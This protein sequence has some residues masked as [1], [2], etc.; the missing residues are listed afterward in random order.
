MIHGPRQ[1]GKTTLSQAVGRRQ[2]YTYVTFDDA[3]TREAATTDPIGFVVDL[4]RRVILDEVQHVPKLFTTLK[5]AIDRN[6]EPGIFVLTGS[7][8]VL[9]L[10]KLADSLAGRIVILRLNRTGRPNLR[11]WLSRSARAA[12]MASAYT[13]VRGLSRCHRA[14]RLCCPNPC[15]MGTR[16]TKMTTPRGQACG[17]ARRTAGCYAARLATGAGIQPSDAGELAQLSAAGHGWTDSR[18]HEFQVGPGPRCR[19]E[20][21]AGLARFDTRQRERQVGIVCRA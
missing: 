6:R 1:C 4:P 5:M 15:A 14:A 13:L 10:P 19:R 18:T 3:V 7:A 8:N 21:H 16:V 11:R 2:G 12:H 17:S 9:L 20:Q